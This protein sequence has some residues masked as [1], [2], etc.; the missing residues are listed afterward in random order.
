MTTVTYD[1]RSFLVDGKRIWLV[2]GSIHYFRVPAA[3]WRD[4]LLK[5]KRAGLN[6]ISTPI[7]WN[8]HEPVEGQWDLTGEKDV[9]AFVR[10]A[11]ELG[12]YVILRPGPYIDS[13]WDGGGLP[14]WLTTKSGLLCRS[15]NAAYTHYYDKYFRK[16]LPALADLQVTRGGNIIL[17][18][19]EHEYVI[20]TM[21][22]RL[23]YLQF[24]NQ[25]FRRSGFDVPIITC[26]RF[27][28]PTLGE[29]IECVNGWGD[30]VQL[31]KRMRLRQ[32][33]A[34]LLMT[35][36]QCAPGS[37]WGPER[38]AR[39]G[40]EV[41]RHAMAVL[42]CGAQCNYTMWH[43]GTN[44]A[45]W[46]GRRAASDEHYQVTS[47]DCGA[48][49]TEAGHLTETYYTTRLV[50]MLANHMGQ[51][52]ASS[53]LEQPG[54]NVHDSTSVMNLSGPLCDWAIITNNGRHDITTA[55]ISLPEGQNLEI[56]L[57][58]I[59]AAAIPI[60][61]DLGPFGMLDY[62]NLTPLGLFGAN[63]LV[64]HGPVGFEARIA[65]N[66]KE[67]RAEVPKD[68]APLLIEHEHML[69]VLVNTETAMRTW[70]LKDSLVF[71]PMFVGEDP[72]D[73]VLPSGTR[74]YVVLSTEGK[75]SSKRITPT[76]AKKPP[77][78]RLRQWKRLAVA[79]EPTDDTLDWRKIDG[80]KD[81]DHL[82]IH[83]GYAWYRIEIDAP[84]AR[85]HSLFLPACEDRATLFLN[86]K[87]VGLWGRGSGAARR[88][89]PTSFKRGRNVLVAMV[90]NLGR[91]SSGS[92]IG[93][94]K[95]LFGHVYDA[96]P[97]RHG[98]F[99]LKAM[100]GF[101]KRLI[102]RQQ[103]HLLAELANMDVWSADLT[104]P[105]T[106]VAPVH[107]S[108]TDLDHHVAI[109]CNDR[110]I[111]FFPNDGRNFADVTLGNELRKGRNVLRL[112]LWGD[113]TPK[114]LQGVSLHVLTETL[115]DQAKWGARPWSAQPQANTL[116]GAGRPAWYTSSFKYAP[117]N[118]ALMLHLGGT[119]KG[120][121][122]LNGLNLG[123][124]WTI[125]SQQ[126]YYLPECHLAGDNEI[127][128]FC[129]DGRAPTQ[130]KLIPADTVTG[131]TA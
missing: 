98:R 11:G 37:V 39:D 28:E 85:K 127:L 86:G 101:S 120:Q 129:E 130:T 27:S 124:F 76:R 80:P 119:R 81:V 91:F 30:E 115:S 68:A 99:K 97:L 73:V 47:Y 66:G 45:F 2:S 49:L 122:I 113:V 34:P 65:L 20:T 111:G 60:E 96:K 64:F 125:G 26:N 61:L 102:P 62:A 123:R 9:A 100:E 31:L 106:K 59:G 118:G 77:T 74:Q 50:N 114:T 44:F 108:F 117:S 70:A 128:L 109:L 56:P 33:N 55:S 22:D 17:I 69:L 110:S 52:F 95:G 126:D 19:N 107:L 82:G 16:I 35:E 72:A 104:I 131:T 46:G 89:I 42:G 63:I 57:G 1:D 14:G 15:A 3:L 88:P 94:R 36:F 18:Q 4:R 43:G 40:R 8:L 7:A 5:A 105:L 24:I 48:P 75:L 84:R 54:V 87:R 10:L 78:P 13:D 103:S 29:S 6:C 79:P 92:R 41:A 23:A 90:D 121:L 21:P 93:T 83:Y 51:F 58:L 32:P 112:V 67:I 25:L 71:G 116:P 38:P 53:I 12:L